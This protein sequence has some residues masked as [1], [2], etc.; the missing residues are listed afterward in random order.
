M[1][2]QRR[3]GRE[4]LPDWAPIAY[5]DLQRE[6]EELVGVEGVN[7]ENEAV[8]RFHL[9]YA[10]EQA[11]EFYEAKERQAKQA[12]VSVSKAVDAVAEV[13]HDRE[14]KCASR[15]PSG[16]V[17]ESPTTSTDN[18]WTAG[19]KLDAESLDRIADVFEAWKKCAHAH[20]RHLLS[21]FIN[22][23]FMVQLETGALKAALLDWLKLLMFIDHIRNF[24]ILNSITALKLIERH[25]LEASQADL[26]K[27]LEEQA[28]FKMQGLT[29][30]VG[31]M[32]T[33]AL[34]LS[35]CL[36]PDAN[37]S[38][39]TTWSAHVCPFCSHTVSNAVIMQ[40]GRACCWLCVTHHSSSCIYECPL[41]AKP[42]DLRNLR[43][44]RVL[45]KFL[46]RYFPDAYKSGPGEVT[47]NIANLAKDNQIQQ[48]TCHGILT[49]MKASKDKAALEKKNKELAERATHSATSAAKAAKAAAQH[50]PPAPAGG[51]DRGMDA[52]RFAS[53]TIAI[54]ENR[55]GS[56]VHAFPSPKSA[57]LGRRVRTPSSGS[58]PNAI[59][60]L[61]F[62]G[63]AVEGMLVQMHE[64]PIEDSGF[65]QRYMR[66]GA[67]DDDRRDRSISLPCDPRP[68]MPLSRGM[69]D[70][71]KSHD[72][73]PN[74]KNIK[75]CTDLAA[76]ASQLA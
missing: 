67:G 46:Q 15:L 7:E 56:G 11:S 27:H 60:D 54:P 63:E 38:T 41:T 51:G 13:H 33:V 74:P 55:V 69:G 50:P 6:A 10:I 31:K 62:L 20:R 40:S 32:E 61:D 24:A 68:M 30:I 17:T 64:Q 23:K 4:L 58:S 12:F 18:L 42:Q 70:R 45:S 37:P 9:T 34:Q 53:L 76:L 29:E 36:F 22:V 26:R 72:E 66:N 47:G 73:L 44:E 71:K 8:F 16:G 75:G 25:C 1:P 2:L 48:K 19:Q 65:G 28:I 3:L 52:P 14:A 39:P 35:T 59:F 5:K 21:D 49:M 57:R 43:A